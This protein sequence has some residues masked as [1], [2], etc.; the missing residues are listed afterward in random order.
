MTGNSAR[1]KQRSYRHNAL[2]E[3]GIS[4]T[5]IKKH[6]SSVNVGTIGHVDHGVSTLSYAIKKHCE[7][8]KSMFEK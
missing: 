3:K 1:K 8:F 7:S 4:N 2:Y 5:L 6:A